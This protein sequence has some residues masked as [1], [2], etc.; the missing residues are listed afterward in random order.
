MSMEPQGVHMELQ[1]VQRL[2]LLSPEV[3]P[4]PPRTE[5]LRY[6]HHGGGGGGSAWASWTG[7]LIAGKYDHVGRSQSVLI[8]SGPAVISPAGPR[9]VEVKVEVAP[10]VQPLVHAAG[11]LTLVEGRQQARSAAVSQDLR[12]SRRRA[13]N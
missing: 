10:G 12:P 2:H 11:L 13:C 8:M 4:L 5:L 6:E 9:T 1:A 3:L 7:M